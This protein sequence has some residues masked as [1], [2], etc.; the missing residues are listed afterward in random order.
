[1]EPKQKQ[2]FQHY[3]IPENKENEEMD[4]HNNNNNNHNN[5]IN[6]NN[7]MSMIRL[8]GKPRKPPVQ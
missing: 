7:N 5:N 3:P 8:R 2:S 6:N 4:H 1:M